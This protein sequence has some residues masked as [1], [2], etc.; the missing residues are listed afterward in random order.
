MS[1][2][3]A[4]KS[5]FLGL[6]ITLSTVLASFPACLSLQFT[7]NSAARGESDKD[8]AAMRLD[9]WAKGQT[10]AVLFDLLTPNSR[11]RTRTRT[12]THTLLALDQQLLFNQLVM[13]KQL[14]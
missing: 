7:A 11:T 6:H 10:C 5:L 1:R 9:A 2:W 4:S 8:L 14:N 13:Q 12:R 3:R